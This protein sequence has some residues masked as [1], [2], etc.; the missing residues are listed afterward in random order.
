MA[1]PG[2]PCTKTRRCRGE[3]GDGLSHRCC[4]ACPSGGCPDRLCVRAGGS[5]K[6]PRVCGGSEA[7]GS[8]V[9]S[10]LLWMLHSL[11]PPGLIITAGALVGWAAAPW[12]GLGEEVVLSELCLAFLAPPS[13]SHTQPQQQRGAEQLEAAC[14]GH[15]AARPSHHCCSGSGSGSPAAGHMVP[16]GG[17]ELAG[18]CPSAG[19]ACAR[20]GSVRA[21]LMAQLARGQAAARRGSPAARGAAAQPA[22]CPTAT[23]RSPCAR[24][25][26]S[27]QPP[28]GSPSR[29]EVPGEG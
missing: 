21:W 8:C 26:C 25:A 11:P 9:A 14:C 2:Q 7:V 24:L 15:R 23:V 22:H 4:S 10:W 28:A 1:W 29:A 27:P 19:H 16:G 18:S 3:R 20:G 6:A 13:L 17:Q 5:A 12:G